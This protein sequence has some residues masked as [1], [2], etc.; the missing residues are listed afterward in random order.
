[1]AASKRLETLGR[2]FWVA[3][4][5]GAIL[6]MVL[7]TLVYARANMIGVDSHA[8][9]M[10]VRFPGTWY[11]SP[12][13]YRDAFLYSPAFAQLLWPLG[14][15]SWPAFQSIWV[16]GQAGVLGWLLAPL[17]WRRGLTLAP[18]F[19]TELLLGNVYLFFAG[20]LVVSLGRAPSALALPLLT[21]ISPGV[22]GIWFVVRR[23]WHAALWAVGVTVLIVG[24]SAAFAPAPWL[25]WAHFLSHSAGQGGG[26]VIP[27]FAAG[28]GIAIWA[29]KTGR[30][31]L[32]APALILAL[33]IL[34]GY[35]PLAVLAA[36]PRL[37]LFERTERLAKAL[38]NPHEQSQ[39]PRVKVI[40]G[41][42]SDG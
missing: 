39:T 40:S 28:L 2:A 29:A 25:A 27:R 20:A 11:L 19:I 15:L 23:E 31:W 41:R 42:Q 30:A 22:V 12:P 13:R 18:F 33:P 10:A 3:V 35:G 17:G 16:A 7:Q 21:K 32:L 8:Y 26:T 1:M 36:I 37:L 38:D 4:M 5:P 34:G 9:W 6:F 24:V 14:Q